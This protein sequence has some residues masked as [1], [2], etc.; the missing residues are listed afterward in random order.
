[1]SSSTDLPVTSDEHTPPDYSAVLAV[2]L[3][4]NVDRTS[5]LKPAKPK[6][7]DGSRDVQVI[8]SWIRSVDSYAALTRATNSELF[9]FL[10]TNL[11]GDAATWYH[12][13][14]PTAS[15]STITWTMVKAHLRGYFI[16]PNND[17]KLRDQWATC[18]QKTTVT[19]YASRLSNLAMRIPIDDPNTYLDKFIRG[20]KP[21]TRIEVELKDPKTIDEALRLA[22]RYDTIVYQSKNGTYDSSWPR[23]PTKKQEKQED[24][25]RGEPMQLDAMAPKKNDKKKKKDA[26]PSSSSSSQ[27]SKLTPEERDHLVEIGACF[28]CRKTGHL[29]KDCPTRASK[30]SKDQ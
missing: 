2:P 3:P 23:L 15:W 30:K 9:H 24:D 14:V 21:R 12:Y 11:I 4:T 16:S 10:N 1:M 7:Y 28:K 18:V 20:L 17:R 6:E 8:D 22:D 25:N 29:A 13:N 26:T 19:D 27:L 5:T